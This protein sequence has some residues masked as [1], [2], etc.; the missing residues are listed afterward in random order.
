M[1][2]FYGY[3]GD[4]IARPFYFYRNLSLAIAA[5]CYLAV[6]RCWL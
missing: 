6:I 5:Y 2:A 3:L 4:V 1:D